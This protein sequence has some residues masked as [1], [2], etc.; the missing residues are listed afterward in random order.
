MT[1]KRLKYFDVERNEDE[2][3]FTITNGVYS[4]VLLNEN[5]AYMVC[6]MINRI[7]QDLEIVGCKI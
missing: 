5:E 1:E 7:I 3:L 2:R 6:Q 4:V